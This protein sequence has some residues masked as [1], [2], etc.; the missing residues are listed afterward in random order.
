MKPSNPSE[1]VNLER[2]QFHV[3]GAATAGA[4]VGE[5]RSNTRNDKGKTGNDASKHDARENS[6]SDDE[7][8][9][10]HKNDQ[11]GKMGNSSPS[12]RNTGNAS[13]VS[14]LS[15]N[16]DFNILYFCFI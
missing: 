15:S 13:H 2:K 6:K 1:G 9:S 11:N 7:S 3:D 10:K 16:G 14:N 12:R 8:R 5:A 4:A